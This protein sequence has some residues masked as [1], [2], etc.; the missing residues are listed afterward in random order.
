MPV[1]LI[2]SKD[3]LINAIP[4]HTEEQV[5]LAD[6]DASSLGGESIHTTRLYS[7]VSNEDFSD[8]ND[9]FIEEVNRLE[10]E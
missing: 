3:S 10:R 7:D 6:N 8:C 1:R 4:R 5:D 9:E 2:T